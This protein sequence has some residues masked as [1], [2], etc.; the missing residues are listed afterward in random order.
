MGCSILFNSTVFFTYVH[1]I[2]YYFY[3]PNFTINLFII[4]FGLMTSLVNHR[5]TNL[6]T[7]VVDRI[8]MI[9]A[10]SHNLDLINTINNF[11]HRYA[12]IILLTSA[13]LIY[14]SSKY[15]KIKQLHVFAHFL[16]TILHLLL[17][18]IKL[19]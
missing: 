11:Y 10:F 7:K 18:S 14:L 8:T 6:F 12:Y 1:L 19:L 4:T 15:L 3:R 17:M 5:Y 9:V 13:A 2:G 16:I